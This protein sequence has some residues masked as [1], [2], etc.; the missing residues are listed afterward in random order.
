[1]KTFL[2]TLILFIVLLLIWKAYSTQAKSSQQENLQTALD[3]Y[4]AAQMEQLKIPGTAVGI[5]Q[6][7]QIVLVKGYGT[8]D[9]ARTQ[10]VTPQTPF[11]LASL[12]K[13]FAALGILQLVEAGKLNLDTPVRE[14]LPWFQ[15]NGEG[16]E[17]MTIRH[18]LHQTSGLSELDGYMR[19]LEPDS[20]NALETSIRALAD[21][22]LNR[23]PGSGYEYSNT[24][25]DVAGLIIETVSGQNYG[26]YVQEHIFDPL[27]MT[28][29]FTT[30]EA[31]RANGMSSGYYPF[32]G[33]PIVYDRW[34]PY[35][36]AIRPS[37]GLIASAEDMAHYLIAHLNG[38][39]YQGA[40]IL[41]PAG[42]DTL[43]TPGVTISGETGYAMGWV[44]FPFGDT[45]TEGE[46]VPLAVSHGGTW[47][48]FTS[49]MLLL[50]DK[51]LGVVTL[52]NSRD[53]LRES[54]YFALAW[55]VTLIA[56]ELE[57]KYYP[58]SEDALTQNGRI[59]GIVLIFV[60]CLGNLFLFRR[61]PGTRFYLLIYL[62]EL[63]LASYLYFVILPGSQSNLPILFGF[64]PD[65]AI[66]YA[67]I[68]LLTLGLGTVRTGLHLIKRRQ[69]A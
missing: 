36:V 20:P 22:T 44:T 42:I 25:F 52:V 14:I 33:I 45:V 16:A 54:A 55:D 34:I 23:V 49:S 11:Y 5:V 46:P 41:S 24:N 66:L 15:I 61:K 21:D 69:T 68:L 63:A 6:G 10:P 67:I 3:T 35:T 27:Q 12:S 30:L 65:I 60:L 32:F 31:A 2:K 43:H 17:T 26:D 56:L 57:P 51:Q 19:N 13:S 48:G 7:D 62:L 50:P 53:P 47:A 18:L 4:M 39:Q 58:P 40:Q 37:S 1:M 38:G 64:V 8:F 28:H 9:A 29:S 59:V